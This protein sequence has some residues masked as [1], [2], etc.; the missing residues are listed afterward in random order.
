MSNSIDFQIRPEQSNIVPGANPVVLLD[1]SLC[2]YLVVSRI[3]MSSGPGYGT[4]RLV[5]NEA[6]VLDDELEEY[7]LL[8]MFAVG[9]RVTICQAVGEGT[10][11]S[12][13]NLIGIFE[14]QIEYVERSIGSEGLTVELTA[15]DAAER[16]D[17]I[18]VSGRRIFVGDNETLFIDGYETVFNPYGIGNCSVEQVQREGKSYRA[19]SHPDQSGARWTLAR[20]AL[21]LLNEYLPY[22]MIE[23]PLEDQ[24]ESVMG[25]RYANDLDVEG[26]TLLE[27]LEKIC[28]MS[29]CRFRFV[30]RYG[31]EGALAGIVFYRPGKGSQAELNIQ[32]AGESL[33][34]SRTN[35]HQYEGIEYLPM[36]KRYVAKGAVKVFESTFDLVKAWNPSLE[37]GQ[38]QD[39]S[40]TATDFETVRD[41][42]RKWCLN[43]A[44][45]YTASPYNQGE[46]FDFTRVFGVTDYL[47][48]RRVFYS[49]LSCD[50]EEQSV[51]CYV[52]ASYDGGT[53]WSEF[54]GSFR[55]LDD[56]CGIWIN[57]DE[58]DSTMWTALQAGDFRI[59]ITATVESDER[60]VCEYADGPVG[61]AAPVEEHV[62][63][64]GQFEYRKVCCDSIFFG[65]E[66]GADETD[67][68]AALLGYVRQACLL[69]ENITAEITVETPYVITGFFPGDKVISSPES[70]EFLSGLSDNRCAYWIDR[71][72]MD[73]DSQT[74]R[75][76]IIKSILPD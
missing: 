38:Q 53:S 68:T 12:I 25:S 75:L 5:Y 6:A 54:S 3:S 20:A 44:G 11:Q 22:G 42:W 40:T 10:G 7:E 70:R 61:S 51:G 52:E 50:S 32:R 37:G 13:T 49:A 56:Q 1:G 8:D 76:E 65:S 47:I 72:V 43:E 60:L 69:A 9:R 24:L 57:D 58:I 28:E 62:L 33:E 30:S 15:V 39:Y 71:L 59:R 2:P 23:L 16:L 41:V 73:F 55:V 17:R 66:Y 67:D 45:D 48:R 74:T 34:V 64:A 29:H 27:A 18:A 4:A 35:V 46:R 19:F 14:G 21:Y 63:S 36:T 31:E 26:D